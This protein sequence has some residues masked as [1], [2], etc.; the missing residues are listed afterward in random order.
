M[1]IVFDQ[2]IYAKA[3]EIVWQNPEE[4]QRLVIRMGSFHTICSFMAAIGKRFGDAGLVDILMESGIVCPGSIAGVLEGRHYN[5]AFHTHKVFLLT[6]LHPKAV[7]K[8]VHE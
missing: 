1:I 7:N 2:A 3:L 4:F 5:R 8:T 6:S